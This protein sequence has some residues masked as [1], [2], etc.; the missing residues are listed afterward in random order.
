MS[1][2]TLETKCLRRHFI[3]GDKIFPAMISWKLGYLGTLVVILKS[4]GLRGTNVPSPS[5]NPQLITW[6][7]LPTPP[8]TNGY[9]DPKLHPGSKYIID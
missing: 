9:S 7:A 1:P 5:P 3:S 4:F 6:G 2:E 8:L